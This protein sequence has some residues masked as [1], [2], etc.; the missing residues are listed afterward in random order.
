M[1]LYMNIFLCLSYREFLCI[2]SSTLKSDLVESTFYRQSSTT[3]SDVCHHHIS[4]IS[5]IFCEF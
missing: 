2:A 5:M 1:D 3:L 4:Q